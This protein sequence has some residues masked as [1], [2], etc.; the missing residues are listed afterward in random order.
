MKRE[1]VV[2]IGTGLAE[3][4][5]GHQGAVRGQFP[6]AEHLFLRS[7]NNPLGRHPYSKGTFGK[8]LKAWLDTCQVHDELGRRVHV[9]A[10]QWRHTYATRLIN[11]GVPQE[12]VRRLLD[13][14]S[15]QMTARVASQP[16]CKCRRA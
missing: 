5:A 16:W 4:I 9:T 12:V 7:R 10:H 13:H 11:A 14:S 1:A 3:T 2:P 8:H 15:H 6:D